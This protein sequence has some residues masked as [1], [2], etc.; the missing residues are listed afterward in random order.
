[1]LNSRHRGHLESAARFL[2]AFLNAQHVL[3]GDAYGA[4]RSSV[5][6]AMSGSGIELPG[7]LVSSAED[8]RYAAQAIGKISGSIDV[9]DVLDVIF[10]DFCIGK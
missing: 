10:R 2:D 9:E 3:R 5:E 7:D 6:N 4:Q 8:L 1:M